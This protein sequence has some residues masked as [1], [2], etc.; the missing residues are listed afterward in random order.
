MGCVVTADPKPAAP[1]HSAKVGAIGAAERL[2]FHYAPAS[3]VSASGDG[4]TPTELMASIQSNPSVVRMATVI[5]GGR[6]EKLPTDE[7]LTPY[8]KVQYAEKAYLSPTYRAMIGPLAQIAT[9]YFDFTAILGG[10]HPNRAEAMT[11]YN[12]EMRVKR[13]SAM[14]ELIK[15]DRVGRKA[16]GAGGNAGP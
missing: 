16:E 4:H 13:A 2:G 8:G 5:V 1:G 7:L 10:W 14:K 9:Y 6:R 3:S 11:I 15:L 12:E